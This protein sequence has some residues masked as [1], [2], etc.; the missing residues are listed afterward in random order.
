MSPSSGTRL[1]SSLLASLDNPVEDDLVLVEHIEG[2]LVPHKLVLVDQ[3]LR[4][5]FII[6][7]ALLYLVF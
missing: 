6:T 3:T 1:G 7:F 5:D 4:F 2:L